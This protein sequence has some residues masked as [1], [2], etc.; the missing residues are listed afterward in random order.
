MREIYERGE[1]MGMKGAELSWILEDNLSL[2]N[3]LNGWGAKMYRTYR[4]YEKNI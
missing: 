4:I 1:K 2:V 3:L